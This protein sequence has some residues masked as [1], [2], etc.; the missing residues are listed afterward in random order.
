M[1]IMIPMQKQ[2]K[3][4]ERATEG[5]HAS[6]QSR[7]PK[8]TIMTRS[9]VPKIRAPGRNLSTKG[10]FIPATL[11]TAHLKRRYNPP[12]KDSDYRLQQTPTSP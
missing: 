12:G 4:P 7:N 10:P 8:P 9:S 5:M 11:L 1:V 2:G 3:S 6:T